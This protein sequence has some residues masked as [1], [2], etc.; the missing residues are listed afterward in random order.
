MNQSPSPYE[1]P[2]GES[3]P[4]RPE[5]PVNLNLIGVI[6]AGILAVGG[7][8]CLCLVA[9]SV[10]FLK[11]P[12]TPAA[13][14]QPTNVIIIPTSGVLLPTATGIFIATPVPTAINQVPVPVGNYINPYESANLAGMTVIQVDILDP[15][16]G[17]YTRVAQPT[18]ADLNAFAVAFNVSVPAEAQNPACPDHLRLSVTR[19]DN[20][21]V[22]IGV[23]L[24]GVVVLRNADLFG[25]FD[26][27]M[28][29]GFTDTIAKY[30]PD[31]YKQ[32]LTF[33]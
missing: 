7:L 18:G 31:A 27:P 20:S 22:V 25:P 30:L 9:G 24:N 11:P 6:G 3:I 15:A 33:Q 1:I 21:V 19:A 32:L 23:C 8:L 12:P 5:R 13:I 28:Y 26:L 16:T 14:S 4:R 29:P 2:P 10:V 17:N